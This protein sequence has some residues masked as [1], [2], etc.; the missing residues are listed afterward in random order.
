MLI[1]GGS[2]TAGDRRESDSQPRQLELPSYYLAR[3]PV[4]NAQYLRFVEATGRTPPEYCDHERF[5]QPQQPVVGVSWDDAVAY[6]EW[7]RLRLPTEWE[8]EKGARGTDGR[9][10][11][12]NDEPDDTRANFGGNVGQPTPVGSYPAGASPY[13]LMDMAGNVWEWTASEY[14][15]RKTRTIRGGAFNREPQFLR[16]AL[17]SQGTPDVRN[18]GLGFRCAQDPATP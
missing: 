5:S 6:G 18:L 2:F 14:V 7:A 13:G 8:W 15:K 16:A 10:Y 17:R 12:W 4:T 11:P 1:P 9:V 3:Y